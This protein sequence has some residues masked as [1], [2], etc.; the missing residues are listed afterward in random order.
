ME[1]EAGAERS[2]QFV[3]SRI[4]PF[5]ARFV[6]SSQHG[7]LSCVIHPTPYT[8]GRGSRCWPGHCYYSCVLATKVNGPRVFH[9]NGQPITYDSAWYW[10]KAARKRADLPNAIIH[11]LRRSAARDMRGAGL[12]EGVIMKLRGWKTRSM[13]DRYN[14]IDEADLASAVALRFNGKQTAN[15]ATP[16]ATPD[17][18]S[19]SAVTLE[20]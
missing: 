2:M 20:G 3:A 16:Q 13:F 9:N 14:I 19:S 10:W 6:S 4:L 1:R 12:S 7:A 11:D 18:V 5:H 15:I 8:V 17:A